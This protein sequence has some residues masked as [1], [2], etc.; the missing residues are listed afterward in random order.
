MK[1]S[2]MTLAALLLATSVPAIA[3]EHATISGEYL[4]ARNADVWTGPCFA[5]GE[6]DIV[7]NKAILAW[8]VSEGIFNDV[9]LDGLG[10]AAVVIG[11]GTFGIGKEVRTRAVLL[12]DDRANETEE[13]AL[14]SLACELAQ[15]TIQQVLEVRKVPFEMS[16]AVCDGLGCARLKAGEAEVRTRCM[17]A[18][19]TICGH[20]DLYYPALAT[21]KDPYAAYS[22]VNQYQGSE[23]GEAFRDSN[24]RSAIIGKFA[25]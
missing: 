14:V 4:E 3:A 5:N 12:V 18:T 22:L 9:R 19:D 13:A 17:C 6:I 10:V 24:A 1:L 11:D 16:T 23:F 7:G 2:S 25:R 21:V 8:K 20:E 15:G